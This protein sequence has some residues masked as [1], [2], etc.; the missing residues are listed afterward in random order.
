MQ[1]ALPV[2]GLMQGDPTSIDPAMTKASCIAAKR[3]SPAG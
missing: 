2:I 1:D 3:A